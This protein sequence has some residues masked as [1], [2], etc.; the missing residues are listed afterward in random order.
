MLASPAPRGVGCRSP[1]ARLERRRASPGGAG[2]PRCRSSMI[3]SVFGRR[4]GL[5]RTRQRFGQIGRTPQF[6]VRTSGSEQRGKRGRRGGGARRG[7]PPPRPQAGGHEQVSSGYFCMV[8]RDRESA[9]RSYEAPARLLAVERGPGERAGRRP[10]TDGDGPRRDS[11]RRAL[12]VRRHFGTLYR[13]RASAKREAGRAEPSA[14]DAS[15]RV[16]PSGELLADCC[17]S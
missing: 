12:H 16:T 5:G 15:G 13:Q 1:P 17:T 8:T 3:G 4:V 11:R 14:T 7:G 2:T 6:S 9:G 10:R